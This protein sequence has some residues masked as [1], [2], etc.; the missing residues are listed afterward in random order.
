MAATSNFCSA[1]SPGCASLQRLESQLRGWDRL[2]ERLDE[3]VRACGEGMLKMDMLREGD[4]VRLFGGAPPK[5]GYSQAGGRALGL[6]VDALRSDG[7][8]RA[9]VLD[10]TYQDLSAGDPLRLKALAAGQD[11][12][13]VGYWSE[14]AKEPVS[15]TLS[16]GRL[17]VYEI[18]SPTRPRHG[19]WL[20]EV[21]VTDSLGV[22]QMLWNTD[23]L[24]F[25]PAPQ[26]LK[27]T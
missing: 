22:S 24:H 18:D 2:G 10:D 4:A 14:A 7:T 16:V 9:T 21:E 27:E 26:M 12:L 8:V 5:K 23:P 11:V 13:L 20:Q 1:P 3:I 17:A 15:G 19:M 25:Q 6:S